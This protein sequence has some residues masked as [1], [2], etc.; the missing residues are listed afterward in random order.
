VHAALKPGGHLYLY[1]E[2]DDS[3]FLDGGQSMIA[4]MN[5]LHPAGERPAVAGA[6]AGGR[7]FEPVFVKGRHKRNL[8]PVKKIEQLRWAPMP[9]EERSRRVAA[10]Y[11][12][13]DRAVLRAPDGVRPRFAGVWPATV[14]RAVATGVARYDEKGELRIV[15][16]DQ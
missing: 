2:I 10:Y 4:T 8:C 13:R 14:A 12:A 3:E 16:V 11:R 9:D 15:N 5:P 6:G 1:N 7:G